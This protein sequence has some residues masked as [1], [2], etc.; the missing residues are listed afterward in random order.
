MFVTK[1]YH[2]EIISRYEE[3]NQELVK[4]NENLR[5]ELK[6]A[7][8]LSALL[9]KLTDKTSSIVYTNGGGWGTI[10]ADA[11]KAIYEDENIPRYAEDILGGKVIK[12]E[13]T[14]CIVINENGE[15]KT[16]LTKQKAD[17]DYTYKLVR[18]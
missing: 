4:I 7:K 6:Q 15:V 2:K 16:G 3:I 10:V 8:D 18:K 1:K 5:K 11:T 17:K 13:G 12:Q 9:E 14:K